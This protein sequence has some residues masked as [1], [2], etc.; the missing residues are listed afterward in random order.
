M[1]ELPL[2]H[3]L[4]VGGAVV[5]W[6]AVGDGPPMVLVHGT[7]FSAQVWRRIAPHLATRRRV[8]YLDL[9]G[10]GR[11]EKRDGLDVSLAVQNRVLAALWR[12][13]GLAEADV[14]AHDFGG[15]TVLRAA[16]LDG[17]AVRTLT[18]VDPVALSPW[19]SPFVTHVRHHEAAFAGVPDAIHRAMLEAYIAGA[20]AAPLRREAMETYLAPWLGAAGK[21]GFYAQ[22]AQMDPRHTEAIEPRLPEIGCPT[23]VVWGEEDA[24][25]PVEQGHRLA[26]LLPAARLVTVP[27]AGHLVQE[28]A[29][30]AVLA[31]ALERI[32]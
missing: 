8:L 23:T 10:Y 29:P 31:A 5:A 21:A 16:L 7:P 24:W 11:S 22:I 27:G 14:L 15:A 18:L 13:W 26:A 4:D 19:G 3:T 6:G 25:I 12:H 17:L 2:D 9:L 30:E 28:D 1:R 20:A 32:G